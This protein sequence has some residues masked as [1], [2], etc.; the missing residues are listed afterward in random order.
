MA[1]AQELEGAS[2][3]DECDGRKARRRE[4]GETLPAWAVGAGFSC[5]R[6]GQRPTDYPRTLTTDRDDHTDGTLTDA[7]PLPAQSPPS[8]ACQSPPTEPPQ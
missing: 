8:C 4:G 6:R 2:T 3:Q 1:G 5:P 7:A